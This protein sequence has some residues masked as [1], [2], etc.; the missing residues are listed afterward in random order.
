M[1]RS[2]ISIRTKLHEGIA[3]S[4]REAY[5]EPTTAPTLDIAILML[6]HRRL[7]ARGTFGNCGAGHSG[8]FIEDSA[9]LW[10]AVVEDDGHISRWAP[11]NE[12]TF[13][14]GAHPWDH[15][16][17]I[18]REGEPSIVE[19]DDVDPQLIRDLVNPVWDGNN[20]TTLDIAEILNAAKAQTM[21][22]DDV[23][24]FKRDDDMAYLSTNDNYREIALFTAD[25]DNC[26]LDVRPIP[27]LVT[28]QDAADS[29]G[30]ELHIGDI[31]RYRRGVKIDDISVAVHNTADIDALTAAVKDIQKEEE[32]D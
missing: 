31:S 25:S 22:W 21:E 7:S 23:W 5:W 16:R 9:G 28:L 15:S 27:C 24:M 6:R 1:N 8:I 11:T 4:T 3:P 19:S 2:N 26:I 32:E 30:I 20:F 29:L 10:C 12:E 17:P 14:E 18:E 13:P